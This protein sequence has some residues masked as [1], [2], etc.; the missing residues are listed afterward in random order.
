[1]LAV[2][3]LSPGLE[4]RGLR[5]EPAMKKYAA[6]PALLMGSTNDPYAWRSIR[7]L[8]AVGPGARE[9]R[10]TEATAHGTVLFSRDAAL[11]VTLVDWFRKTLL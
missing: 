8:A 1:V 5:T 7:Q 10:L 9:V 6:R 2:A 4:Y 11:A 3:L